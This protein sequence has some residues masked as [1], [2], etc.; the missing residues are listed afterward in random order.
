[1]IKNIKAIIK[2][3][4]IVDIE[5]TNKETSNWLD[6]MVPYADL[7]TLLLIFFVFFFKFSDIGGTVN[8]NKNIG[9]QYNTA[10]DSTKVLSEKTK[11]DTLKQEEESRVN[12]KEF[13]IRIS[14]NILFDSGEA[15]LKKS[16]YPTLALIAN[17]ISKKVKIE[18]YQVR[19]E[20]HTDNVPIR[21]IKYPSNWE[22]SIA[23]ALSVVRFFIEYNYF[24]PDQLQAMGY[25]EHKP[26]Y[27]NDTPENRAKNR[28]VE[29]RLVKPTKL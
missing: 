6:V 7:M 22:L 25:G 16:A 23:R 14:N 15:S 4:Q 20:G 5:D 26:L 11:I 1:M 18:N 27:P 9:S 3:K 28:R 8:I 10:M 2:R 19:V 24:L 21:T 12:E 29:I 13:I 17:R